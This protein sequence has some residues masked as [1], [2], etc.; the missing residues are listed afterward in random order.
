M[1]AWNEF[2]LN[3]QLPLPRSKQRHSSSREER[4]SERTLREEQDA[5]YQKS[6]AAD[7]AKEQLRKRPVTLTLPNEIV[8]DSEKTQQPLVTKQRIQRLGNAPPPEPVEGLKFS[9]QLSTGVK[10]TRKFSPSEPC[11]HLYDFVAQSHDK[12]FSIRTLIPP[13]VIPDST[14]SISVVLT[15]SQRLIVEDI[16]E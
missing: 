5:A 8:I 11:S 9:F 2:I 7:Q 4:R 6:L 10:L 13:S 12:D 1:N 15:N 16:K 3:G 14:D